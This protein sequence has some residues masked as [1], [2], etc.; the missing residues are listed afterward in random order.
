MVNQVINQS[1][2]STSSEPYPEGFAEKV[3]S[4]SRWF[5]KVRREFSA[6]TKSFAGQ[7]ITYV[8][9]GVWA[10]ESAEWVCR[11]ILT[12]PESRGIGIDPYLPDPVRAGHPVESVKR[13][14]AERLSFMGS[15]W[16]WIYEPSRQGL[17]NTLPRLLDGQKIDI[18]YIDGDHHSD[19]ALADFV[20][21]WPHLRP[22]S[23]VIFDD[24][25]VRFKKKHPH[26]KET[27][28]AVLIA[29]KGLVEPIGEHRWQRA[30]RVVKVEH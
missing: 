26:V 6:V 5:G 17:I 27:W 2:K 14:A 12:H 21:G 16:Q 25:T 11:N 7:P 13:W 29:W 28:E 4:W 22:G 8:E 19:A 15:R 24:Y 18:F 1:S 10:G 30:L 23:V 20:L 9:I 3:K